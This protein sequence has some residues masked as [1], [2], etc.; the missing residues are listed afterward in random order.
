MPASGANCSRNISPWAI[1]A[2]VSANS[3]SNRYLPP[4]A[5]SMVNCPVRKVSAA[6]SGPAPA[7]TSSRERVKRLK[8]AAAMRQSLQE[9]RA[10]VKGVRVTPSSRHHRLDDAPDL[11][12]HRPRTRPVGDGGEPV[13][14]RVLALAPGPGQGAQDVLGLRGQWNV[15]VDP[16][17]GRPDP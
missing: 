8:I 9:V 7:A 13:L 12:A 4:E 1:W 17:Q 3:M 10:L 15:R 14:G 2:G 16:V 6:E 5:V 11:V